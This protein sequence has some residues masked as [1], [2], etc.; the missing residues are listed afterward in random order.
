MGLEGGID[1]PRW[2]GTLGPVSSFEATLGWE[3]DVPASPA[4]SGSTQ[5]SSGGGA[6]PTAA[7]SVLGGGWEG[8]W[9]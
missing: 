3:T 8:P 7:A 5:P 1:V 2:L 9:G 4:G 6:S